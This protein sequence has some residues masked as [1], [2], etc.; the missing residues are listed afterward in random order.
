MST[1]ESN[2]GVASF[3]TVTFRRVLPATLDGVLLAA[4]AVE[5]EDQR[6][7]LLSRRNRRRLLL[8]LSTL[9]LR[10]SLQPCVPFDRTIL[11]VALE[12]AK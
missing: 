9:A 5:L 7:S 10:I 2:W 4:V 11:S 1:Q 12:L 8:A 3:A 6:S